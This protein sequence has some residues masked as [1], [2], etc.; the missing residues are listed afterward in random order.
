MRRS[1][2]CFLST[3]LVLCISARAQDGDQPDKP[4]AAAPDAVAEEPR[5][6]TETADAPKPE[7][8]ADAPAPTKAELKRR[9]EFLRK[10]AEY[11]RENGDEE[12]AA[13][14]EKRAAAIENGEVDLN[15]LRQAADPDAGLNR[16]QRGKREKAPKR[17][18]NLSPLMNSV[19]SRIAELQKQLDAA[20]EAGDETLV[21]DL[22]ERLVLL[23]TA[24]L[25]D[26]VIR[27]QARKIST[28]EHNLDVLV[29]LLRKLAAPDQ[30]E[31]E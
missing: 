27:E 5:P 9:S 4:D 8:Q 6:E 7:A 18:R 25:Q 11:W 23:R 1:V 16:N 12:K 24:L 20:R 29:G 26:A 10:A 3:L 19:E 22:N 15:A 14:F 2:F 30:P 17:S 13:F 28:L 31:E 21:G